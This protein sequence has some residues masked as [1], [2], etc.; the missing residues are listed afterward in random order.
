LDPPRIWEQGRGVGLRLPPFWV[1]GVV[2]GTPLLLELF[3][4]PIKPCPRG[5]REGVGG[6]CTWTIRVLCWVFLTNRHRPRPAKPATGGAR[7][8]RTGGGGAPTALGCPPQRCVRDRQP[9]VGSRVPID[10][11]RKETKLH[12]VAM[13]PGPAIGDTS[14]PT[15]REWSEINICRRALGETSGPELRSPFPTHVRETGMRGDPAPTTHP[16]HTSPWE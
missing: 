2:G 11:Q 13:W 15:L 8:N 4:V 6:T 9:P 16:N 3:L 7:S 1:G 5:W 10:T 12:S 14:V